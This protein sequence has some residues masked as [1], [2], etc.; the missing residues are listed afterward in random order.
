MEFDYIEAIKNI[1]AKG[2][3]KSRNGKY[4]T[5]V[6]K[7]GR[8][9]NLGTYNTKTEASEVIFKYRI[10]NFIN[11]IK[12]FN[13][14]PNRGKLFKDN[15]LVFETGDIFNAYG[16]RIT[17]CINRDGYIVGIIDGQFYQ[18]HRIVAELFLPKIIGREFVN[19]KDGNKQ[20]NNISN[21]EWCTKSENS[22][23]SFKNYL[24]DNI[25]N[26]YGNFS[27]ISHDD[28]D[29]IKSNYWKTMITKEILCKYFNLSMYKIQNAIDDLSNNSIID[30]QIRYIWSM[31]STQEEIGKIIGKCGKS[32]RKIKNR[33]GDNYDYE[34]YKHIGDELKKQF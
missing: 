32:V 28:I 23:H 13:L 21:L 6:S 9:L 30:K 12:K 34:I 26:Q 20:N 31:K 27:I 1:K 7:N 16:K 25:T 24:Q 15:Y 4:E 11:S 17:G 22:I 10:D 33:I 3:R 5:F 19:H 29:Y 8:Y 2:Y 18:F 14:N